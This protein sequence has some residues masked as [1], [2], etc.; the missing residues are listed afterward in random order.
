MI[1]LTNTHPELLGMPI[2]INKDHIMSIFEEPSKEGASVRTVICSLSG[3]N[4]VVEES[5]SEINKLIE[6]EKGNKI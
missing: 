4:W 1:K 5:P 2:W 6:K 3:V